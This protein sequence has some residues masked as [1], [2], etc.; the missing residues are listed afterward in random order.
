[1]LLGLGPLGFSGYITCQSYLTFLR[2]AIYTVY[3]T[4]ANKDR[5]SV[6][7]GLQPGRELK[8][9][10]NPLTFS[11]IQDFKI[12]TK[13]QNALK[14]LPQGTVLSESQ[15]NH[16]LNKYLPK[17]GDQQVTRIR[18]AAA[19]AFYHQQTDC[20]VVQTLCCDDAPQFKLI[21]ADRAL[22]WVHEGRHYKKLSPVFTCHQVILGK[23]IE[24]FWDY[25][26]ELLAYKDAPNDEAALLLKSKFRLLFETQSGYELLDERKQLT[27]TKVSELLR[28]LEHPELPLHNNPAELAARTMVQRRNISYATQTIEGTQAWDTFMSLVATTR[29][30][31]ISFFDYVR[32]RI[33]QLGIIPSL[34]TIIREKSSLHPL[35]LSW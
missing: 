4:T 6:L 34:S 21:T 35:G 10:L 16:L 14:L 15:F 22:C 31:G 33:S 1:M 11:L 20:P 18:E 23:F 27:A 29:Q 5:L 25:Y 9:M 30:L 2:K 28:V 3:F 8:F 13:W 26:R 17:L 12:P 24:N 7:K 32:D 19:I